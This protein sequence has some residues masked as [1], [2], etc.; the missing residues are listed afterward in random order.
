M[1][2]YLVKTFTSAKI[3]I[4]LTVAAALLSGGCHSEKVYKEETPQTWTLPVTMATSGAPLYYT[5]VGSVVSDQ[6]VEV[7]SKLSGYLHELLVHEGD[8]VQ[9]GQLLARIDATEVESGIR[10]AEAAVAAAESI[11]HDAAID[12]ERFEKLFDRGSLSDNEMR[13]VRLRFQTANETLKQAEAGLAAARSLRD[14]AE[15]K[16]PVTG[17]VIARVKQIGDLA[18]PGAPILVVEVKE[19]LLLETFV[20]ESQVATI[21]D[22]DQVKVVI[23]GLVEPLSGLVQRVVTV[24]DPV[25]RSYLVKIALPETHNLMPGMFGRV[26][27]KV[28]VYE[29]PIIPRQALIERGGLQGVFVLDGENRAHFR[30]LRIGREWSDRVE[31]DAGLRAEEHFVSVVE[32][33]LNEGDLVRHADGVQ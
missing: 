3:V 32:L 25:T 31:V 2:V 8:R 24:A 5:A 1:E 12:Q 26:H 27:F 23:D 6:K 7:T 20:A 33:S 21:R 9:V 30:W 10:Q 19:G 4:C 11:C 14:Y 15:I 17:V 18:T 16:S 22:G 13:K 29:T 28:G